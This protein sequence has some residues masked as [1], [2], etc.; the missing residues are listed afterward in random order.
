M[1]MAPGDVAPFRVDSGKRRSMAL[2]P[3]AHQQVTNQFAGEQNVHL[4]YRWLN[5]NHVRHGDT[6]SPAL[7]T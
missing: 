7:L 6:Q 1:V 5:A 3:T 2:G 4:S